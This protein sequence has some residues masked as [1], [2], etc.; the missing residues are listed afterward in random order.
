MSFYCYLLSLQ[1]HLLCH[2]VNS[3]YLANWKTLAAK[4]SAERQNL[5]GEKQN[6][7]AELMKEAAEL[8]D[9]DALPL[10]VGDVYDKNVPK[11]EGLPFYKLQSSNLD[12]VVPRY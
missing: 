2:P 6:L 8:L 4:I 12:H 5:A 11:V 3:H 9:K 10:F 1:Q 7:V